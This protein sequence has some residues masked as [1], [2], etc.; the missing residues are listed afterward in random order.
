MKRLF[1]IAMLLFVL[2]LITTVTFGLIARNE[3]RSFAQGEEDFE[4]ITICIAKE[5]W[6]DLTDLSVE[7]F[8]RSLY[9]LP[10][11]T[12]EIVVTYYNTPN[13][14]ITEKKEGN[15]L[16]YD[17]TIRF[18]LFS[19]SW[20]WIKGLMNPDYNRFYLYLPKDLLI[21]LK[22]DTTNGRLEISDIQLKELKGNTSNGRI[23]L[24]DVEAIKIDVSTSN[25]TVVANGVEAEESVKLRTSNGRIT[26]EKMETPYL[27]CDTS[28]GRINV[29]IEGKKDDYF[30][31][32]TT[33]NGNYYVNGVKSLNAELNNEKLA[34]KIILDTS[35]GD[36]YISFAD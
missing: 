33:T 10:S 35:N 7:I 2:G 1:W 4:K 18:R 13:G 17:E 19:F 6:K 31:S 16:L 27:K 3:L 12:D 25:G 36:I 32:M 9:V 28:N 20:D 29:E 22:L 15:K 5:E 21:N 34:K 11:E 30:V 23:V 24:D 8:N 26:V 14:Y